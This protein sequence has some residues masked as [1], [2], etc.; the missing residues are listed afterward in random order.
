MNLEFD[1]FPHGGEHCENDERQATLT[2]ALLAMFAVGVVS[3][4][5]Y[6]LGTF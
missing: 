3:V 1:Y 2:I 6:V 5:A 4:I